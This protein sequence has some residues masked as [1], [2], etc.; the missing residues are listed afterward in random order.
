MLEIG[1]NDYLTSRRFSPRERAAVLWAEH[2]AKN[3]ARERDDVFAEVKREFNDQELVEL[4]GVCG[5]FGQ[6]NRFQDSMCLPIEDQSEVDKIRQSVRADPARIKIYLERML[7]HW[8]RE[9]PAPSTKRAGAS[10]RLSASTGTTRTPR[11]PLLDPATASVDSARFM[12]A[13]RKLLGALPSSARVWAHVP[14]IGKLFLPFFVAFERDGVGSVL[15]AALRL[16]AMLKTHHVLAGDYLLAHHT[17]LARAAGVSEKQLAALSSG[18]LSA[19]PLFSE[20]ERAAIAWA[21]EVARNAAKRNQALYEALR[22]HFNDAE[23]VELT[24]LCAICSYADLFHNA[25]RVAVEAPAEIEAL[26]TSIRI[27]PER[28]RAYLATLL[29]D[30]PAEFPIPD[31]SLAA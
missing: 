9:F 11:V 25:L 7:E 17:V 15:S 30:W 27:D 5:L 13:A 3:T 12:D 19:S 10:A 29:A 21:G 4:T 1:S 22:K 26:N 31:E 8:P 28:L 14:H 6:S 16:M 20:R 2:V 24:G 23:V 18:D